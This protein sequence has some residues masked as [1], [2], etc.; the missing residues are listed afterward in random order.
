MLS[1]LLIA[2]FCSKQR[3]NYLM[4]VFFSFLFALLFFF[5]GFSQT[6]ATR[7]GHIHVHSRSSLMDLEGDNY[8]M[9]ST[10]DLNTGEVSFIGLIKSFEFD[11]GLA[12]R[13][14]HNERI[15]VVEKPKIN[16]EGTIKGLEGIN[17]KKEGTYD[18]KVEGTLYIWGY[19]RITSARGRVKVL[20]DG[21]LKTSS[22]FLMRIEEESVDKINELMKEYL[23]NVINVDTESLG[24]SRDIDVEVNMTY[25]PR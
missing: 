2:Y 7:T 20:P 16:F 9:Y 6:Y 15:N 5:T 19:K 18:V 3:L 21:S 8:Q 22:K 12:D 23:P 24:I 11:L 25:R 10:F 13:L 1:L 17:L 4:K 14:L